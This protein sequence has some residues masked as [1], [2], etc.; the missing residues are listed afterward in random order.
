MKYYSLLKTKEKAKPELLDMPIIALGLKPAV[1][2]EIGKYKQAKNGK[3]DN[4]FTTIRD[5]LEYG[6][7]ELMGL[8]ATSKPRYDVLLDNIYHIEERLAKIGLRF[9]D[10]EFTIGDVRISELKV[11]EEAKYLL[12][13]MGWGS[14]LKTLDDLIV[15]NYEYLENVFKEGDKKTLKKIEKAVGKYGLKVEDSHY[16]PNKNEFFPLDD[17]TLAFN[18]PSKNSLGK[19][20]T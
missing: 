17:F 4:K 15:I 18:L 10:T 12:K 5:L 1:F 20:L 6:K 2:C 16:R 7:N 13:R 11:N 19:Y 3:V 14:K 8:M 9:N